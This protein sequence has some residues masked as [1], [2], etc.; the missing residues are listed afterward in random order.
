LDEELKE[1]QKAMLENRLAAEPALRKALQEMRQTRNLL[2]S[3]PQAKVPH[4]FTLS[5]QMIAEKE[6]K[7]WG[8][9]TSYNLL[10]AVASILLVVVI[11]GDLGLSSLT[12]P[13]QAPSLDAQDNLSVEDS[14]AQEL[15]SG[16]AAD[17]D[18][19]ADS[20]PAADEA[21]ADGVVESAEPI[22][23]AEAG[24]A[25]D[26]LVEDAEAARLAS[27]PDAT[28]ES[29]Q[30]DSEE[31]PSTFADEAAPTSH[32]DQSLGE[33]E[34]AEDSG[35]VVEETVSEAEEVSE[36]SFDEDE[37]ANTRNLLFRMVEIVLV[38]LAIY[39]AWA[40]RRRAS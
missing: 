32:D 20:A 30:A 13:A 23:A 31:D 6:S 16:P 28:A 4:H 34:F 18:I 9:S 40:A 5:P 8:S 37:S 17:E 1:Q 36:K 2:R 3:S 39:G 15:A 33:S 12:L 21:A 7:F 14:A 26:A 25:D 22:A 24:A 27:E 38:G 11:I 10:S 35:I 19:S 29:T